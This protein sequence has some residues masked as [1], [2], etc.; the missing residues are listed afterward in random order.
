MGN[1]AESIY[2]RFALLIAAMSACTAASAQSDSL[3]HELQRE[4]LDV[5]S[6]RR[7]FYESNPAAMYY[8]SP[9]SLSTVSATSDLLKLDKAVLEQT[10]K[11]HRLFGLRAASYIH[12]GGNASVWGTAEFTTG[13]LKSLRWTDCID[14][15]RV[16][17]FVLGDE[18]GGDLDSRRYAFSGG[19]SRKVGEW[20][21]G[22]AGA[23]RA[24]LAS[25]DRDPRIKTI[26]S[27][28]DV[29]IGAT[30]RL[31]GKY[32]VGLKGTLN[33]YRQNCDLDFYN[34]VNEIQ[35]YPLTGLGTYYKRFM[36]NT[37]KNSGYEST[38][39][40]VGTQLLPT[41]DGNGIL[42]AVTFS[43]YRMEQRLRNFNNLTLAYTDNNILSADIAYRISFGERLLFMP[44]LRVEHFDR[45]GTENLFGTSAGASYDK[46]GSRRPYSDVISSFSLSMPLQFGSNSRYFTLCPGVSVVKKREEYR[47]PDRRLSCSSLTPRLDCAYS[48]VGK[49]N[50]LWN[51]SAGL[52]YRKNISAE[53]SFGDL[54]LS[55]ALGSCVESNFDMMKAALLGCE[56]SVGAGRRFGEA[57]Y[58]LA[59]GYGFDRYIHAASGHHVMVTLSAS[60]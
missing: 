23:Y 9:A 56:A 39:Y 31:A 43:H 20:S 55:S 7:A 19:Y 50:F 48:G 17:P 46:I 26:V 13:R 2:V 14:Y 29:E 33:I 28:I 6:A 60:F 8:R 4:R 16:A 21:L 40:A 30:R 35:T 5:E 25:R 37:N 15:L 24:E 18:V 41:G 3:L 51:C 53:S 1:L 12:S 42:G 34:P 38:G 32:L 47:E 58:M 36:G 22:I 54:D 45:K 27:D 11:G 57:V 49:G 59:L 44:G 52:S 10:G